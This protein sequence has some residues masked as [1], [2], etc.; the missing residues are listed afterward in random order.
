MKKLFLGSAAAVVFAAVAPNGYAQNRPDTGSMAYPQP[1]ASGE[2]KRPQQT[3]TDTGSMAYPTNT[4]KGQ[5]VPGSQDTGADTGSMG[6]PA[7]RGSGK[8]AP[9]TT[10]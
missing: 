4:R 5:T 10:K 3:G 6:Y 8:I 7:A 2:F 1:R 9:D